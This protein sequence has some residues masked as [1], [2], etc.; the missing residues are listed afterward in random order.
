LVSQQGRQS[1]GAQTHISLKQDQ[2]LVFLYKLP[3]TRSGKLENIGR[4]AQQQEDQISL[5][6]KESKA[7]APKH[8]QIFNGTTKPFVY[9]SG[10]EP[11]GPWK[12]H[13]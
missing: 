6:S 11:D 5:P 7:S 2:I 8:Y 9:Q 4:P 10:R 12:Y 3:Q 13:Q 1:I